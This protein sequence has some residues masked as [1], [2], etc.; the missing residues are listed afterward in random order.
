MDENK[1]AGTNVG[2]TIQWPPIADSADRSRLTYSVA[3]D[4]HFSINNSGQLETKVPLDHETNPT[5]TVTV[6]ATDPS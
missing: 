4:T 2:K 5:L 1:R 3:P 6:T